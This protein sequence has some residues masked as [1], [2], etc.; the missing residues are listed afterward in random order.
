MCWIKLMPVGYAF[1]KMKNEFS[2]HYVNSKVISDKQII[3]Q[4]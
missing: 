4:C 3:F 2:V 1:T